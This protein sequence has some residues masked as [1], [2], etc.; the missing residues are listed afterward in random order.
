MTSFDLA[1]WWEGLGAWNQASYF[2]AGLVVLY[3]LNFLPWH[4]LAKLPSGPGKGPGY[5]AAG[6]D[7]PSDAVSSNLDG[8]GVDCGSYSATDGG[9]F[10]GC[11]CGGGHH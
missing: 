2:V 7:G 1:A 6:V 4:W 3:S 9:D 5:D 11:D 10:S 8:G